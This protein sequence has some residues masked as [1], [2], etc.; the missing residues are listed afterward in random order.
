MNKYILLSMLALFVGNVLVWFQV[1]GQLVWKTFQ[2][3]D[4]I[5]CIAGIPIAYLFIKATQWGYQGLDE[6]LWPLRILSFVIGM[7]VFSLMTVII[8]HEV[9]DTKTIISLTLCTIV[10]AI[11]VFL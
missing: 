5:L 1:N 9:P 3:N 11:Q 7:I 4:L 8:L 2:N 6:K 10:L